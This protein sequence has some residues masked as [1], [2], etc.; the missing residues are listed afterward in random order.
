CGK[1]ISVAWHPSEGSLFLN[2]KRSLYCTVVTS[3]HARGREDLV[4]A[5]Q[6]KAVAAI[7]PGTMLTFSPRGR[8]SRNGLFWGRYCHFYGRR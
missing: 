3:R 5:A 4:V 2:A 7:A 1:R 8:R 6:T